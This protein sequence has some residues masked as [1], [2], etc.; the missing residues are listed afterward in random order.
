MEHLFSAQAAVGTKQKILETAIDLFSQN[1][2]TGVSVR[3]ITKLVGIKESAMYNHFKNKDE[4]LDTIYSVFREERKKALPP[5]EA[6]P[7]LLASV[8]PETFLLQG[9]D[10]FKRTVEDPLKLKIWRILN[11]EQYRDPR[12]RS[13]ILEDMYQGTIDFLANVFRIYI[14]QERMKPLDPRQ[15]A[16]EY[17]YPI[18]AVMTEYVLLKYDGKSTEELEQMVLRHIRMFIDKATAAN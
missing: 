10:S 18:F 2:F 1:G 6:L 14:E 9:F 3:E 5:A 12:A 7:A 8:A 15:L 13:I 16:F 11:I 17:Q 4:I